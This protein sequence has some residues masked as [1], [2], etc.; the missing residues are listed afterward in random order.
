[1]T[2]KRRRLPDW[3]QDIR[4]AIQNIRSDI[5]TLTESQF[6]NTARLFGPWSKELLI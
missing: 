6:L 4:E 2:D 3:V 5:G 1:M